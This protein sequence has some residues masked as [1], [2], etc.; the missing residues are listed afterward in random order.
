MVAGVGK[1][2][3]SNTG[4]L[5]MGMGAAATRAVRTGPSAV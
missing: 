2:A 5:E 1:Q 4:L 3:A